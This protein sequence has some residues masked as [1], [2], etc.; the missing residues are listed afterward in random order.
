MTK[1]TTES[2]Y[3]RI[4]NAYSPKVKV[5]ARKGGP[6]RTKQS[7][8]KETDLNYLIARYQK[9][10]QLPRISDRKPQFGYAPS[11]DFQEALELVETAKSNFNSL[12]SHVRERFHNDPATFLSFVENPENADKFAEYGLESARDPITARPE[13]ATNSTVD[14]TRSLTV[15]TDTKPTKPG[16]EGAENLT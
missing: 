1:K 12:P 4:R 15:P 6:S 13:D 5:P 10:G 7:F 9:T 3:P 16:P 14:P 11:V 2:G 8:K